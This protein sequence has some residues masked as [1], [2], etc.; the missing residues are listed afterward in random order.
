MPA[1][2]DDALAEELA[3][4]Q[5]L[6]DAWIRALQEG[7]PAQRALETLAR[8]VD[9]TK[10]RQ[11]RRLLSPGDWFE[12]WLALPVTEATLPSDAQFLPVWMAGGIAWWRALAAV[13]HHLEVFV[14]PYR[15]LGTR[16]LARLMAAAESADSAPAV[17]AA[18]RRY[19]HDEEAK[20]VR[21]PA[22]PVALERV[23]SA[24]AA[25]QQAHQALLSAWLGVDDNT[26]RYRALSSEL[27]ELRR[28]LRAHDS[29]A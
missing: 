25:L 13:R 15:L 16:T 19:Q 24:N 11:V 27:A 18:W 17:Y 3:S 8:H 2:P 5:V 26:H 10:P 28:R 6:L 1:A 4:Y 12:P 22:W 21:S 14:A 7:A 20:I 9:D 29:P 23:A